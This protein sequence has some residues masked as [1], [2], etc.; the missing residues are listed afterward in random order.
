MRF[1]RNALL[2][3]LI[4]MLMPG[5]LPAAAEAY[6]CQDTDSQLQI[7]NPVALLVDGQEAEPEN[8]PLL[9]S[10]GR[11]VITL[12]ALQNLISCQSERGQAGE[13]VILREQTRIELFPGQTRMLV[14]AVP[15][16][17][18]LAPIATT[19]GNYLLPL[20]SL[21]EVMGYQ[22]LFDCP[23]QTIQLYSP[24]FTPLPPPSPPQPVQV[25]CSTLPVWG[26]ISSAPV[27]TGLWPE[28]EIAAGFFTRLCNSPEGRTNN[29]MLSAAK[30][31]GK[32]L[33]TD[34]IFSFNQTV[35]P[36]TVQNGYQ[37]AKIFAGQKIITGIGGG[38]CQTS[39]TLYN[40]ALEAGLQ[41][42]ERWP[43]SLHVVY[44][45][46]KRDATVSWGGADFKFRNTSGSQL[47]ILCKVESGYVFAAFVRIPV[48][49][50]PSTTPDAAAPV[51]QTRFFNAAEPL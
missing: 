8:R 49:T 3:L 35:G 31:N 33:Q 2:I 11:T 41:V 12:Q 20:R 5:P 27:L 23:S 25:D 7:V 47:R 16:E 46:P 29:I 42:V 6:N 10:C 28:E 37:N 19:D 13:L 51:L 40:A 26:S 45:P 39:S 21:V 34:E 14:N 50:A 18:E 43:H 30:I 44:A 22:V 48:Q 32:I 9:L 15:Q 17:L 36:R 4:V 24:G 1:I 38:I